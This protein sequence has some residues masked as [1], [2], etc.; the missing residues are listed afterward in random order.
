MV[1]NLGGITSW[2]LSLDGGE[3]AARSRVDVLIPVNGYKRAYNTRT[4]YGQLGPNC[5]FSRI[6]RPNAQAVAVFEIHA[7]AT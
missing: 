3:V 7:Q 5:R 6:G 2:L 1:G 4:G